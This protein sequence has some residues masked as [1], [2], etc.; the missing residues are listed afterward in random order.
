MK[1]IR[2]HWTPSRWVTY[3]TACAGALFALALV[4]G[5]ASSGEDA[6]PA[7][8]P[9]RISRP[10]SSATL[11]AVNATVGAAGSVPV[12]ARIQGPSSVAHAP[13]LGRLRHP[14]QRHSI[15]NPDGIADL[16]NQTVLLGDFVEFDPDSCTTISIGAWTVNTPPVDGEVSFGTISGTL[17]DGDC[18]G[19]IFDFASISYTWTNADTTDTT[20]SLTATWTS[21]D[22]TQ[23]ETFEIDLQSVS[24]DKTLGN[25][26]NTTCNCAGDPIA[27]GTGNMYYTATDYQT[28]GP[29][30]L[31]FAR[32]YNSLSSQANPSTLATELGT[33]WQ[34][35]Y[36]RSLQIT[37]AA[38]SPSSV[39]AVRADG[40]VLT[41]N[42]VNG[43][44][45]SE[46]DVNVSLTL[47][48]TTFTLIDSNDSTET[49]T[50][51]GNGDGQLTSIVARGGY[52]QSLFYNS[53]SQL[54][55]VTDMYGRTLA[56]TYQNGLLTQVTT[57]DGLILTYGYSSSGTNGSTLDR[58]ASVGYST[59]PATSQQ[60][61]YEDANLPFALTGIIDENGSRFST[62]AYDDAA[63]RALSSQLGAGANLTTIAYDDTTGDRTVTN[64][65]GQQ[66]LYKFQT[67]QSVPKVIEIDRLATS[68]TAA[69]TELLGYDANGFLDSVTDWNGNLKTMVNNAAG[70]PTKI[71]EAVG[72]PEQRET[73]IT[74]DSAFPSQPDMIVT[75]GLTTSYSY[76][77]SG[78]P[79]AKSETDTTSQTS[80]YSTN[81]TV[82]N[83]TYSF[84]NA[85]PI[86]VS[87]PR[88]DV[89]QVTR[90]GY[91]ASGA[92]T[93]ITDALDHVTMITSHTP[94]GYPLVSIDPNGVATNLAYAPRMWLTTTTLV[95]SSGN[96][97]TTH[98]RDNVGDEIQ[99]TLPDGSSVTN[100]FDAAHRYT[101]STN[102]LG[103]STALTLDALGD[104]QGKA[105]TDG[106]GTTTFQTSSSFNALGQLLQ[107]VGGNGQT[108]SY[109]LDPMGNALRIIDPLGNITSQSFDHLNRR[110]S[111]TD[112]NKGVTTTVLDAHNQVT[113]V[114]APNGAVTNYIRDGFEDV[115]ELLSPD[116]GATINEFDPAGNLVQSMDARGAIIRRSFDALNRPTSRSFPND[117]LED[118]SLIYD[119]T[120]HG[121][122][123]GR[124]TAAH[125]EAGASYLDY[126]ERGNILFETR[127]AGDSISLLQHAFDAAGRESATSYPLGLVVTNHRDVMGNVTGITAQL[128]DSTGSVAIVSNVT[129]EAFGGPVSGFAYGNGIVDTK[130]Y[131]LSYRMVDLIESGSNP[132]QNLTYAYFPTNNVQTITDGVTPANSQSFG[133]DPLYH[134]TAATGSYG[135][136][137]WT[138]DDVGNRLTQ[139]N[140]GAGGSTYAYVPNTN[141]LASITAGGSVEN[142]GTTAAGNI[143]SMT[144]G[145]GAATTFDYD[146]A[147][148]L[149][150]TK[151]AGQIV[152]TYAY[153]YAGRRV[154]K[155]TGPATSSSTT[156]YQYGLTGQLLAES[157]G[158]GRPNTDYIYL[159]GKPVAALEHGQLDFMHDDWLGTPQLM[160]NTA[161]SVVWRA[162]FQP[163]GATSTVAGAVTQNLRFPGQY[164]DVETGFA[165]NGFRDY[166][167]LLGRYIE[168]DPIGLAGGLNTFVYI[169]A[170]PENGIDA[171][172]LDALLFNNTNAA[173]FPGG[174]YGH[175]AIAVGTPSQGYFFYS[176]NG[177]PDN[178]SLYFSTYQELL[179]YVNLNG[180]TGGVDIPTGW[181]EDIAMQQKGQAIYNTQYNFTNN[182]CADLT[183]AILN[184]GNISVANSQDFF[185]ITIPNTQFNN[186]ENGGYPGGMS[187]WIH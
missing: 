79:I 94:G 15:S 148:R 164:F 135:S 1:L 54:D 12:A 10:V 78:S 2:W 85:L 136:L 9:S 60:Y 89:T 27:I 35:N 172:G 14:V 109:A 107:Q 81:G 152:A 171:D 173:N 19:I 80:P 149:S 41:F 184:A 154:V 51:L 43:V 53:S 168:S 29:N 72:A 46:S 11:V 114:A 36:D 3:A 4:A 162:T 106:H 16:L 113:S 74:Y 134:L 98:T 57:P 179:N 144:P 138:L 69:A 97:T 87:G 175:N 183:A 25:P 91:D 103:E 31:S 28:A 88:T 38:G 18:P 42:L 174:P 139:S 101:G 83:W 185:G 121:F 21:P 160:T 76:N 130:S 93:S 131:D 20:D 150:D 127:V 156:R 33:N 65:L 187:L 63:G 112:P 158:L 169:G 66:L 77:A 8:G 151:S 86:A 170:N 122:G 26:N 147:N 50:N 30:I 124:L 140:G 70:R 108:I 143:A 132:V 182:N 45:I 7:A 99:T 61:V 116:S 128:P 44:W 68:T 133:Y 32:Y 159:D 141:R 120:G 23:P 73:D 176:K 181:A 180:Y 145:A 161:Q 95:T 34:S 75:A 167:S 157:D 118:V 142:I 13:R 59:S 39:G 52:T 84:Q 49:Y 64:A 110:V 55:H 47:S 155:T 119:Q 129:H 137:A 166:A 62:W 117:P 126:D 40:Q 82:R 178:V 146:Q 6:A 37:S 67:L 186:V 100:H 48:G 58:L 24:A 56:F 102:L 5:D 111:V 71:L 92:L 177:G 96:L 163:F 123:I 165:Q 22:F 153:D 115:I 90:L 125:D 17:A 104:V 105:I